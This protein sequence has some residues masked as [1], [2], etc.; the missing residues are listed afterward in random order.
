V[1]EREVAAIRVLERDL[2]GEGA[3]P[4]AVA[5]GFPEPPAAVVE[6]CI[7]LFG[8]RPTFGATETVATLDAGLLD[9][10]LPQ[11]N[12]VT[13]AMALEQCR[14]LL[15]RRRART[16]VSGKVRDLLLANL[17]DPPDARQVASVLA[18][19]DR[20]LRHRLAAEGTTFRALLDEVRERLAEELLVRG[21]LPV[22]EVAVRLGYVEVSSFS[23][24]FR[25][26][27]GV[28]PREYRA[29]HGDGLLARA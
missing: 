13:M 23:Q 9:L 28:G 14:D 20:T 7:D 26:W 21:G 25:R 5:F 2:L 12:E 22:S 19:S 29:R 18:M 8:T 27:K 3:R 15:D 6:R 16:G 10:P 4:V 24:A 17:A 11:A 1:V